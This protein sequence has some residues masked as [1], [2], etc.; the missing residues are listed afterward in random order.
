MNDQDSGSAAPLPDDEPDRRRFRRVAIDLPAT[1]R[2][3]AGEIDATVRT[4]S[5]SGAEVELGRAV[6]I[7]TG[8]W[9][10]L[11]GGRDVLRGCDATVIGTDGVRWRLV[12]DPTLPAMDLL[13]VA[14]LL[15]D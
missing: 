14:K 1:V 7:P 2:T 11:V 8:G 5:R 6:P 3:A 15:P 4:I 12:F 13:G 10:V 9:V